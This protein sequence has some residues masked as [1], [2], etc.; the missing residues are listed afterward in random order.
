[1]GSF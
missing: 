1:L